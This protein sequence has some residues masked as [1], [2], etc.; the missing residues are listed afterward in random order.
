M[1]QRGIQPR[2][3]GFDLFAIVGESHG[4][5]VA[6][7]LHFIDPSLHVAKPILSG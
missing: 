7:D 4:N 6:F 2:S 3:L 1:A 5:E